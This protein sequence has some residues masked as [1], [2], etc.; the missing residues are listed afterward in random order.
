M[1]AKTGKNPLS[2][3]LRN[4]V[5]IFWHH[6]KGLQDARNLWAKVNKWLGYG[7]GRKMKNP[8]FFE[9]DSRLLKIPSMYSPKILFLTSLRCP[10]KWPK[11]GA[12]SGNSFLARQKS[13]LSEC[14]VKVCKMQEFLKLVVSLTLLSHCRPESNVIF[15][16]LCKLSKSGPIP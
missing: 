12:R 7:E 4:L 3:S 8:H 5:H 2:R 10:Y 15:C 1:G 16:T 14:Q 9:T 13:G 6:W 11:F